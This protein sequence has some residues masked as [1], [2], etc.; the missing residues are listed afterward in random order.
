MAHELYKVRETNHADISFNLLYVTRSK[1]GKDW[2]STT[3]SHHFTELFYIVSGKGFFLLPDY[4]I[5]V[6][7]NDLVIINPHIEHT[8]KSNPQDSLEYIAIGIEGIAFTIPEEKKKTNIGLFTYQGEQQ[9]IL[10]Y[11]N[12]LVDEAQKGDVYYEHICKNIIEILIYK[13]RREKNVLINKQDSYRINQ[14]VALIKHYIHQ[15]FR[16]PIT[17]DELAQVAN[18]NKYYLAHIFK[19]D[20]GV[21]PIGYLNQ[22]RI[23]EAK[24]LLETTNYTISE[25]ARFNGFS[26]Q[27]FFSQAFKRETGMTP[28]TYRKQNLHI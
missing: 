19:D 28:S 13:L 4:E 3:H 23:Q 21:S 22:K 26:S 25:I 1:Y 7:E 15:N 6:K 27:S 12:R 24:T 11:L 20:V 2:H 14:Y 17:L 8:E 16:D 18:I 9:S 10:F 5:P